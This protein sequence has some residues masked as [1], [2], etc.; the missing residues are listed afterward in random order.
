[1][2]GVSLRLKIRTWNDSATRFPSFQPIGFD[3]RGITLRASDDLG[4]GGTSGVAVSVGVGV[5][6][7]VVVIGVAEVG[8]LAWCIVF[9][10]TSD[11][12]Q[13]HKH[14]YIKCFPVPGF[15]NN[16]LMRTNTNSLQ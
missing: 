8:I 14:F 1:V 3:S 12:F 9:R 2:S 4:G 15:L 13:L 11:N 5:T 16:E 10:I 7:A 6:I